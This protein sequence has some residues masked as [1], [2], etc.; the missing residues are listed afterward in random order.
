VW[1]GELPAYEHVR[2]PGKN[3]QEERNM[4]RR[5]FHSAV[6]VGVVALA[7]FSLTQEAL[8][9]CDDVICTGKITR[10][11]TQSTATAVNAGGTVFIRMNVPL[12]NLDCTPAG[13][14]Q[15][16]YIVLLPGQKLF[17]EIYASLL[18]GITNN[19]TMQ[20]R[21]DP[22]SPVCKV[23]YVTIEGQ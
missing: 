21:I 13:E 8:A 11:Y 1:P 7:L 23:A 12:T 2:T 3:Q 6:V 15:Q 5:I 18:A 10:L 16:L 19:L 14:P 17:K 20:V 22:A 4:S 9:Q